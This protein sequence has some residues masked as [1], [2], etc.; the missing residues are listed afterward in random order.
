MAVGCRLQARSRKPEAHF[1]T[2]TRLIPM[3][4]RLTRVLALIACGW[5]FYSSGTV[6]TQ[7]KR[8]MTLVDL[9]NIPRIGDPQ[10]SPD[11]SAITFML[12]TA[13][14]P[15]NRRVAHLWRINTDGTGLRRLSDT[16]GPPPSARWSP[17]SSTIAFL[18]G[19]S[20]YVMPA[21]GGMP[22]QVSKRT[23]ATDIAWHPDGAYIYFLAV[24][25]LSD[26]TRAPA[27]SRRRRRAR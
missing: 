18:S 21:R 6:H 2:Y 25:T 9:L 10:I 24:D 4:S 27:P 20:I 8:P 5:A 13:D 26:V 17:D 7:T 11:G 23:G 12:S 1:H 19:G 15:A 16:P 14:W 22:R 3:P